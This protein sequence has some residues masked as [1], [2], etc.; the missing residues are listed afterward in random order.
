M[1]FVEQL[2]HDGWVHQITHCSKETAFWHARLRMDSTGH[3]FRVMNANG[4]EFCILTSVDSTWCY[5]DQIN[6]PK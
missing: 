5:F 3:T 2:T 4:S 6:Y 1:F